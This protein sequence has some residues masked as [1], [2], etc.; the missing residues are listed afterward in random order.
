MVRYLFMPTG[1]E[2]G[3]AYNSMKR[4]LLTVVAL[5]VASACLHAAQP[6]LPALDKRAGNSR[7]SESMPPE[8]T[9]GVGHLKASIPGVR[10]D[11]DAMTGAPGMISTRDGFLSRPTDNTMDASGRTNSDPA[12]VT[13]EFI[14]EHSRVFGHGPEALDSARITRDFASPH[15]GLR[16]IAWQQQVDGV[17]VFEAVIVSHVTARDELVNVCGG[18]LPQPAVHAKGGPADRASLLADGLSA[19]QAVMK[20]AG[21][22]GDELKTGDVSIL[23]ENNS[24]PEMRKT[25]KAGTLK[26]ETHAKLTWLP[27][28]QGDWRL[29]WDIIL[30]GRNAGKMYRELVDVQT[31]EIQIRRCLSENISDA[32]YRVYTSDSPTPFSPGHSTPLTAQ[33]PT[34]SRTLVTLPAINTNASPNGWINDGVNETRGNNVDAHS[35]WNGDDVPDLPR[36]QGS[37]ARVFDFTLSLTQHPTNSVQA[38]VVQLFYTC[39]WMHDKLYELGFT[40]AAGNF[41]STNFGRGGL[42]GDALQA[43]AQDGSDINNAV[44]ST[45]PDGYAPRMEMFLFSGP[46]P[47][48]DGDLDAEVVM[49]EYTHGLSNRRVGGGVGIS[50]LQ[51]RGLGEGWSDFYAM[52]LLSESYDDQSGCYANG[53]YISHLM[54]PGFTTNYYYGIRRYPYSTNLTKNPLTFRDI[55]PDQASTHAGIARS[56][57]GS[58]SASEV[59]NVGE[60]WCMM[61]WEARASLVGKLGFDAGNR[62][63]L[64]LATDGM[65]LTPANPTF[66]QAR[67]GILQADLVNNGGTNRNEL[68]AAFAKRGL[69]CSAS[70]PASS[71]TTG[72]IE[73]YDLPDFLVITPTSISLSGPAGGPFTP[74]SSL[75]TL[76]NTGASSIPWSLVNTSTWISVS[77]NSGTLSGNGSTTISITPAPAATNLPMGTYTSVLRVTNVLT[78]Q[79]QSVSLTLNVTPGP[80]P[81]IIQTQPA[82]QTVYAGSQASF[83]VSAVSSTLMGFQWRFNATNLVNGGR[84]SGVNSTNLVIT[85]VLTNDAGL[86]SVVITNA[87]GSTTSSNG[88]LTVNS[89]GSCTPPPPGLVAWWPGNGHALD[90]MGTNYGSL[91]NGASFSTGK[92]RTGFLLSSNQHVAI[93]TSSSI[94]VGTSSGFTIELWIKPSQVTGLFP[95][96][97]WNNTNASWGAHFY[98]INGLLTAN[99]VDT[100][101]GQH[102]VNPS[103]GTILTNVLQH[104]AL[105]YDKTTGNAMVYLNSTNICA[106]YVGSFTPQTSYPLYLGRRPAQDGP[107]NYQ[108]VMDEVSLYNRA[109]T[110]DEIRTI[111]LADSGGKCLSS[112]IIFTHPSNQTAVEGD[113]VSF[114]VAADGAFPMFHQWRF[115]GTNLVDG[116]RISGVNSTNLVI[117]GVLANDTG[118][119]SVVVTNAFGSATSSNAVLTVRSGTSCQTAPSGLVAWW[120]GE[121]SAI[122][123]VGNNDGTEVG[124]LSY[125]NGMVGRAMYFDGLSGHVEIPASSSLNVGTGDGM[126]IEAWINPRDVTMHPIVEYG[127]ASAGGAHFWI[128][129]YGSG[130]IY[131]NLADINGVSHSVSSAA[132]IVTNDVTQH[133]AMTYDK[134]T[135][136]LRFFLNGAMVTE[137]QMGSFTPQTTYPLRL[138]SRDSAESFFGWMDEV[139]LYNRALTIS[140]IQTI[141][142]AGNAGKCQTTPPSIQ[143]H[144]AS[145]MAVVGDLVSFRAAVRGTMPLNCQWRFNGTNLLNGGR[146]SGVNSTNLVITGV[147]TNDAGLYSVMVTNA[148][149]SATSSNAVLTVRSDL[150]CHPP[151][152]IVAWW[153][154]ENNARDFVNTNNGTISSG[155]SFTNGVVGNCFVFGDT[156]VQVRFPASS[157]LDVKSRQGLTFEAW[158]NPASLSH[159]MPI[160]E[161]DAPS[162]TSSGGPQLWI[163]T[164]PGGYSSG[165]LLGEITGTDGSVQYVTSAA[166]LIMPGIWQ[167]VAMTYDKT[168]G[169]VWLYYNGSPVASNY[170][171][172]IVPATTTDVVMGARTGDTSSSYYNGMIDE[173]SIY[174][175]GL[176]GIEIRAIY[177]AGSSG[178]C[179]IGAPVILSQPTGQT[180]NQGETARFSV[181]AW[182]SAAMTYQWRL[183]GINLANDGRISGADST[184]LVITRAQSTDA[185]SYSVMITNVHGYALSSNAVLSVYVPTP[186]TITGQPAS[187]TLPAGTNALFWATVTGDAPFHYQWLFNGVNLPGQTASNL[188]LSNIQSSNAGNYQVIITNIV[189]SATSA[190]AVLTVTPSLPRL[191]LQPRS[192]GAFPGLSSGFFAVAATG[193]EPVTCQ[194]QLDGVDVLGA[195]N[196]TLSLTNVTPLMAGWYRAVLSNAVGVC[197]SDAALLA[198]VPVASWGYNGSNQNATPIEATNAVAISAG[199][200]HNVAL[201][202]D[203][204]VIAWGAAGLTNVPGGL[205]D[206][207]S[208]AAGGNHSMALKGDGTVVVWGNNSNGELNIPAGLSNVVAIAAGGNHCVALKNNGTVVAWGANT[209]LQST[210]PT[211]L[212]NVIAIA[213]GSNHCIALTGNGRLVAWGSQTT[214]PSGLSDVVAIAAG[215][216]HNLALKSTGEAVAWGDS[217]YGQSTVPT[218]LPALSSLAGGA[219]H[220][221]A[222]QADGSLS[223]WGAGTTNGIFPHCA[224]ASTPAPVTNLVSIRAGAAHSLALAA[225]GAPF[226]INPPISRNAFSGSRCLFQVSASGMSPR[227]YQWQ[228]N[229]EDIPG[230]TNLILVI[231][232]MGQTNAG[233]YRVIVSNAAGA[234]V[235]TEATL[236]L[237]DQAPVIL[238]QP[239]NIVARLGSSIS[240]DVVVEG[241]GPMTCQWRFNGMDIEG[242][243]NASLS[244]PCVRASQSGYY[245]VTVRNSLGSI[246]STKA[247]LAVQQVV[248]WGAGTAIA[249]SPNYGQSII[250]SNLGDVKCLAGGGYHSLAAMAAGDVQ[251]WGAGTT[252]TSSPHYGQ[253]MVPA[254]ATS[255]QSVSAG[256]A[257]SLALKS[258]GS[259]VAWGAGRNNTLNPPHLGQS[260]VPLGMGRITAIAAGDY[261]SLALN[262][263]G[264]VIAWGKLTTTNVP[265]A[266]TNVIAIA[267]R[268]D[269][270]LALKANGSLLHWGAYSTLPTSNSNVVGIAVGLSHFLALKD[271]ST[272][273]SWGGSYA[274]PTGLS[275]IVE[276]AAGNDFSLALKNDGTVV[277]WGATNTYGRHLIP[278][279]LSNV[280]DIACGNYHSLALLGDGTP[281]IKVSPFSRTVVQGQTNNQTTFHT[282]AVGVQPVCYQWFKNGMAIA[283]ATNRSLSINQPVVADAGSYQVVVSNALGC[284]SSSPAALTVLTSLPEALNAPDLSWTTGSNAWFAQN[285]TTHDG[286]SAGQSAPI[287]NNQQSSLQTTVS[288]VGVLGFWWKVSSEEWFDTLSFSIDDIQQAAISGNTGWQ[289]QTFVVPSGSHVLKWTYSKDSAVAMGLDAAWLDQVTYDTNPPVIHQQPVTQTARMSDTVVLNVIATGAAPIQYQWLKSGTNL[290]DETSPSFTINQAGRSDSGVYAVRVSNPCGFVLSSNA[291]VTIQVPQKIGAPIMNP[292]GTLVLT[293][294][295]ADGNPITESTLAALEVQTSTNLVD[296]S[297]VTNS[298]SLSNN[299]LY[300]SLPHGGSLPAS[301]F[302]IIEH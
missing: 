183:N 48:R 71:T 229:E 122:D 69:G 147:M 287:T 252:F 277:T 123:I 129:V 263:C 244:L 195:T 49:H 108:G 159:M 227:S 58:S 242:A 17:A 166:G 174:G 228:L 104:V 208:V 293:S 142:L 98:V 135:G 133:V 68:W 56:P 80:V 164:V 282:L 207:L 44:M 78:A 165:T 64:Q 176:S 21:D 239:T 281:V 91:R 47:W 300:L 34:V 217:T 36:P 111:Y 107:F 79:G 170:F 299:M 266:A 191:T 262:E 185:G 225:D 205:S 20:A 75:L 273:I 179:Q 85:G 99:L 118:I 202:R 230:A 182:G 139:S 109:L 294:M 214:V 101:R 127:T 15:N 62:L 8:R 4:R 140:E 134:S 235:S 16:T 158:I 25:F 87:Y 119:Y 181:A 284:A 177:Q 45:P 86:Y 288:G 94:N 12:R 292:D 275:N 221:L 161:Y 285:M 42:E 74:S 250:S 28:S 254:E 270:S 154:G 70:A 26:G 13:R 84:F 38:A 35:D 23:S 103:T 211:N 236:Q 96:L 193:T 60:V 295:D 24:D 238:V 146:F 297:K 7:S 216:G 197:L 30:T 37:P 231:P 66:I 88:V 153:P 90:V 9:A 22:L 248:A 128:G 115:N 188:Y 264:R 151:L 222:I 283:G 131:A 120:P 33:P 196:T 241:S 167:H 233:N 246:S 163:S 63:A 260:V 278:S 286:I 200:M 290:P 267:A 279:G 298:L 259:I 43:D 76:T 251:A 92:V 168:S 81:P 172:S 132:G 192:W 237:I 203:G 106:V 121:N 223:A 18:F 59:H 126:S 247:L 234:A 144:P 209:S 41:Q 117:T 255:I 171:G 124:G 291:T 105:T 280:I 210:P 29:C 268:G 125:T 245:S 157:T 50:A 180:V 137:T 213:A 100:G 110:P 5:I 253:S 194:W 148:Y 173:P 54:T 89:T 150:A 187:L 190:V 114:H 199:A 261:H 256:I 77:A 55:D 272:L 169:W 258:D 113:T 219:F 82:S 212:V 218:G 220:S 39:N 130:T 271:D 265:A 27:L 6:P 2:Q 301:Y 31:G 160:I 65:N 189:G 73:A 276:I 232:Q 289:E 93:P 138:G 116:G 152:D 162:P 83:T 249:S 155:V 206:V 14:R 61:L 257:H 97:E 3:N 46:T 274:A 112:P 11:F 201:R 102:S 178:K 72:V 57:L 215:A 1:F 204:T 143:R 175:R 296:W 186:P 240:M 184:D 136:L 226:I 198:M 243:T 53:G 149:G 67:D 156:D 95:L 51:S 302:R 269:H 145:Q 19:Q 32:S 52:A 40:E 10:V 224:Q 141:Y